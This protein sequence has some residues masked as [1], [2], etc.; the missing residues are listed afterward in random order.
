[1]DD[2][3]KDGGTNSTLK[4]KE[5][6][7]HDDDDDCR[8]ECWADVLLVTNLVVL[9]TLGFGFPVSS[10]LGMILTV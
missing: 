7:T 10:L 1:M 2:R 4:T 3:R 9:L 8:I 6:G 5:Q